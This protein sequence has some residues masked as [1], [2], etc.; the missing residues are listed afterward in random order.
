[1]PRTTPSPNRYASPMR[2]LLVVPCAA[3]IAACYSPNDEVTTGSADDSEGSG[4]G[5]TA[6]MTASSA[7]TTPADTSGDTPA[8]TG[9]TTDGDTG[10]DAPP[11]IEAFSVQGSLLPAEILMADTVVLA[12]DVTDDMGVARVEFYD[13]GTLVATVDGAPWRTEFLVTSADNGGHGYIAVA[14]DTAEQT[15][16]AG[17]IPLSVS[18]DGGAVIELREEVFRSRSFVGVLFT[19]AVAVSEDGDVTVFGSALFSGQNFLGSRWTAIRYSDT[20]SELW[21]RDFPTQVTGSTPDHW[22]ISAPV[23]HD[24]Q[25]FV[26]EYTEAAGA[27]DTNT[28]HPMNSA[29]GAL[30]TAYELE[31]GPLDENPPIRSLAVDLDGNLVLLTAG[32]DLEKLDGDGNVVWQENAVAALPAGTYP[33]RLTLDPAG[34]AFIDIGCSSNG[35]SD[36]WLRKFSADGTLEWTRDNGGTTQP[37]SDGSVVSV[38]TWF[39]DDVTVLHRDATGSELAANDLGIEPLSILDAAATPAGDVVF[40]GMRQVGAP[41]A[42]QA[43]AVRTTATGVAGWITQIEVGTEGRT[44][45]SGVA[46]S[47][48]GRLYVSGIADDEADTDFLVTQADA[49]VAELAL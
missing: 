39:G 11:V 45:A 38:G 13:G 47:A 25:I 24:G 19:P 23:E 49:W 31:F 37:L 20:L 29:T 7:T 16:E 36:T 32:G 34:N 33:S 44:T 42:P 2:H 26:A 43:W 9:D 22:T 12:A 5:S 28:I 8:D 21:Q 18:I 35:C 10:E 1:M 46:V 17:P 15:A 30:G 40:V 6:G 48:D 3:W 4:S 14:Y 27:P 41:L